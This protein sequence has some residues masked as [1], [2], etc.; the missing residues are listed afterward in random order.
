LR[1]DNSRPVPRDRHHQRQRA[2]LWGQISAEDDTCRIQEIVNLL[3]AHGADIDALDSGNNFPND[4]AVNRDCS[5]I[6]RILSPMMERIYAQPGVKKYAWQG[7]HQRYLFKE[8][9]L[10]IP[11]KHLPELVKERVKADDQDLALCRELLALGEVDIIRQL[12]EMGSRYVSRCVKRGET[13]TSSHTDHI[14]RFSSLGSK[15]G[16]SDDFLS[17]LAQWGYS[18]LLESLGS[19]IEDPGWVN[20]GAVPADM[21]SYSSNNIVRPY[22]LSGVASKL[23]NL[24]VLKIL[25]EK[26]R[27]DENVQPLTSA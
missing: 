27:A 20:G 15:R 1:A 12:P 21:T 23:P 3:M 8:D 4:L 7:N 22:I 16:T 19:M 9:C 6:V 11:S 17:L 5:E 24:E 25:F 10:S 2:G 14:S 26:Y 13:M 18:D